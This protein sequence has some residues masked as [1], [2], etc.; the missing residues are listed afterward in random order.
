MTAPKFTSKFAERR[1]RLDNLNHSIWINAKG[2]ALI[3]AIIWRHGYLSVHPDEEAA[4]FIKNGTD[5][6]VADATTMYT[7]DRKLYANSFALGEHQRLGRLT[8]ADFHDTAKVLQSIGGISDQYELGAELALA[9]FRAGAGG[10]PVLGYLIAASDPKFL[11]DYG[12][13]TP[14]SLNIFGGGPG[15]QQRIHW[16]YTFDD[17]PV[18]RPREA[19]SEALDAIYRALHDPSRAGV[20]PVALSPVNAAATAG[21]HTAVSQEF[22]LIFDWEGVHYAV[23]PGTQRDRWATRFPAIPSPACPIFASGTAA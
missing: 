2:G 14:A 22:A 5:G 17:Q 10:H 23:S 13:I 7:E 18:E 15:P 20:V 19:P 4:I 6:A 11:P 1:E 12:Q 9:D 16:T 21:Q 3:Q 8:R